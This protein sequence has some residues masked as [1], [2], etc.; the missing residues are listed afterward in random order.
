MKSSNKHFKVIIFGIG[1]LSELVT[2]FLEKETGHTIAGYCVEK[3]F[4]TDTSEFKGVPIVSFEKLLETFNPYEFKLFIAVGNNYVRERIYNQSKEMGYSMISHITESVTHYS[5]LE[6][7]EN[8]LISGITSLQPFVKV[9]SNTIIFGSKIGHHSN[10]GSHVMLSCTT[11]GG[12]VK[13]GDYSFLGL[14]SAIQ[15]DTVIGEKNIIGMGCNI[16]HNTKENQ[17]YS[18]ND[19]TIKRVVSAEQMSKKYL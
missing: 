14:N 4:K 13:I 10:I 16:S 7:G 17:V 8:V 5:D 3:N 11:I 19:S 2:T 18:T 1:R 12:G 15:H 6:F 9:G